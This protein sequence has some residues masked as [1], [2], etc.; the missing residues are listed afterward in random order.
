MVVKHATLQ[1]LHQADVVILGFASID[2]CIAA[3]VSN[4]F[5]ESKMVV[6]APGEKPGS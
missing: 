6:V 4:F 5:N 2:S 3:E 1:I